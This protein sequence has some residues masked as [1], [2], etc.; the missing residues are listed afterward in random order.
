[1]STLPHQSTPPFALTHGGSSPS[2][3]T[4]VGPCGPTGGR[5]GHCIV[6]VDASTVSTSPTSGGPKHLTS[7]AV[8]DEV[9]TYLQRVNSGCFAFSYAGFSKPA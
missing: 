8:P 2:S 6:G 1:M 4:W 9:C 3:L 7:S 5:S